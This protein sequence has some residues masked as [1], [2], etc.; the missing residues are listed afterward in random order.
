[1]RLPGALLARRK[2]RDASRCGRCCSALFSGRNSAVIV[3][4]NTCLVFLR[5]S[6]T[7]SP[8][9][10][11][12]I[13]LDI[14][15]VRHR[16]SAAN[17]K[18][19]A[20]STTVPFS[21]STRTVPGWRKPSLRGSR[22][23]DSSFAPSMNIDM[24][25]NLSLTHACCSSVALLRAQSTQGQMSST[26]AKTSCSITHLIAEREYL[27]RSMRSISADGNNTEDFRL[28]LSY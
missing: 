28:L 21:K 9:K 4:T 3:F 11:I 2:R 18:Y 5:Q 27:Q 24:D 17:G 8:S 25:L 20:W 1:L 16:R 7:S 13:L 12:G 26:G 6:K 19:Q 14:D 22:G 15:L 23:S 10:S